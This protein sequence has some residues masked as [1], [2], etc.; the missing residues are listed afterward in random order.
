MAGIS[1]RPSIR[2]FLQ[3]SRLRT[4]T[5]NSFSLLSSSCF[6]SVT[7]ISLVER[8]IKNIPPTCQLPPGVY[9]LYNRFPEFVKRRGKG[10]LFSFEAVW[11]DSCHVCPENLTNPLICGR[12]Y[13]VYLCLPT[14]TSNRSGRVL[15]GI[16]PVSGESR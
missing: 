5:K 6:S 1:P 10:P 11:L 8:V 13:V 15:K 9:T 12:I 14:R 2:Q 16:P 4:S 3:S 7:E